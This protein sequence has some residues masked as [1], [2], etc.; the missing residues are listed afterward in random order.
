VPSPAAAYDKLLADLAAENERHQQSVAQRFEKALNAYLETQAPEKFEDKQALAQRVS[1]D[2]KRLGLAIRHPSTDQ[3][4]TLMAAEGASYRLGQFFL[5]A[6]GSKKRLVTR[7]NL[8]DLLPLSLVLATPRRE[9]LTEWRERLRQAD[10]E[11]TSP[12]R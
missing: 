6:R 12:V 5:M 11:A 1:A 10:S 2:L 3:P 8:A 9:P 7:A 4:C